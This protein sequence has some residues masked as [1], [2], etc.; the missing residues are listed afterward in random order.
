MDV[1]IDDIMDVETDQEEEDEENKEG[2]GL[3]PDFSFKLLWNMT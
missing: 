1:N 3:D 2:K